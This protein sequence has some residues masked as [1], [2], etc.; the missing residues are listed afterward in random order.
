MGRIRSIKPEFTQNESLSAL[1]AETHLF[2]V[3]LLCY[4][5]DE[6]YFNANLGLVKASVFPLRE[7]SLPIHDMFTQLGRIDFIRLGTAADGK[8]YGRIVKF[9]DHQRVNR[10]TASKIKTLDV[11]WEQSATTHAALTDDS[12]PEGKGRERNVLFDE[13][14]TENSPK[15]RNESDQTLPGFELEGDEKKNSEL[16]NALETV[17]K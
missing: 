12:L 8:R 9:A 3:G 2:A 14:L 6:G 7:T 1:P 13:G 16:D 10:P 15:P 17:F 5:D 11:R 4:A